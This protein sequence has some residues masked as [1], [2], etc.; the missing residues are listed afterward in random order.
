MEP[1]E[2]IFQSEFTEAGFVADVRAHGFLSTAIESAIPAYV[3][4]HQAWFDHAVKLSDSAQ[5]A[6]NSRDNVV[7]GL[8]THEPISIAMRAMIRAMNAFQAAIILLRRGMAAEGDT[9]VRGIYE[10]AF[11]LGY[12]LEDEDA[13]VRSIIVDEIESQNSLLKYRLELIELGQ[14]PS[15]DDQRH[16][17]EKLAENKAK[18]GKDK[19]ISPKALAKVSG[20]YIYY[21]SYKQLSAQSAHTSLHSLH[22]HLK[23]V[24]NGIYE[25]HIMG[26]DMEAAGVSLHR[27]CVAFGIVAAYFGAITG[28]GDNDD[29]LQALLVATDSIGN[30]P[31]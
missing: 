7:V 8:S 18:L 14:N 9:I 25:G 5:A 22:R 6:Y 29:E 26:P 30:L 13:A 15:T 4:Q 10:T 1:E 19:A 12:L 27:A 16:I 31:D 24:G 28:P 20:L 3:Y 11:W 23:Y 2:K 21:D 17:L